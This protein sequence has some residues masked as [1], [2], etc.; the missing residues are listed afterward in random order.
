MSPLLLAVGLHRPLQAR[1][2]QGAGR[3]R[4]CQGAARQARARRGQQRPSA[5]GG[6]QDAAQGEA[7]GEGGALGF[8][9]GQ[10][11]APQRCAPALSAGIP[12]R[13]SSQSI[14]SI[15]QSPPYRSCWKIPTRS[16]TS[17]RR[18]PCCASCATSACVGRTRALVAAA[19]HTQRLPAALP[20]LVVQMCPHGAFHWPMDPIRCLCLCPW[21]QA[22]FGVH[23]LLLAA[24][25]PGRGRFVGQG[26]VDPQA[27]LLC[28]G[29]L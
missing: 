3:G 14:K 2:A 6:R 29:V 21:L 24:Q 25:Q 27:A 23:R 4:I 15:N 10:C 20:A 13:P 5:R 28:A 22:H 26:G 16:S 1:L 12:A 7:G 19:P 17:S 8:P 9:R 11:P 18:S